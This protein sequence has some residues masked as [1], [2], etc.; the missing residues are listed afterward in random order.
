M[1]RIIALT[2]NWQVSESAMTAP[3]S[4]EALSQLASTTPG[5][6]LPAQM[7]AQVHDVLLAAGRIED[8]AGFGAAAACVWVGERNWV[9]RTRFAAPSARSQRLRFAGVDTIA[10]VYLN[11]K[12]IASHD[13]MFLP[14][15]IDVTGH[16]RDTDNT[17]IVFF[18]SPWQWLK[19]HPLPAHLAGLV[20]H[21]RLLRKPQEDFNAFNGAHPYYTTI[22]IFGDVQLILADGPTLGSV[23]LH[24]GIGEDQKGH[25]SVSGPLHDCRAGEEARVCVRVVAPDGNVV[26]ESEAR[27]GQ[28]DGSMMFHSDLCVAHPA[29]WFPRGY[30]EQPLYTVDVRLCVNGQVCDEV[31]TRA[32]FRRIEVSENFDVT[33]NGVQVRLWGVNLTPVDGHSKR[34]HRART[35]ATLELAE[36]ANCVS[37]RFWGPG[38]PWHDDVYDECDRRGFLVWAE[39][40]HTW[41][42]YPDMPEYLAACRREAAYEVQRLHHH[43]S[44]FLWC[45]SNEVYMGWE[46]AHGNTDVPGKELYEQLYPQVVRELDP[47]Q[48][49]YLV[50]SPYGGRFPNDPQTGNSHSYTHQHFVPGAEH[51]LLFTENTRISPPLVKSLKRFIPPDQFWPEGFISR[52]ALRQR[53]ATEARPQAAREQRHCDASEIPPAWN[54]LTLGADFI[55]GRLGPIGDFYDTGDT[56]DGLVYRLGAAHV[57]WLRDCVERYRRGYPAHDTSRTVRTRGHYL[58]KFNSTWPMIYSDLVDYLMEPN[59]SYYALRRAYAP[60]LISMEI[61]DHINLWVV[62]DAGQSVTGRLEARLYN[63]DGT[64]VLY[65]QCHDVS[66]APGRS[67]MIGNLD[68]AGMFSRAC[69]FFAEL[70]DANGRQIARTNDLAGIERTIAFPD[71]RIQLE[72]HA[73]G[74]GVIVTTDVFAR[75]VEL[76]GKA[77]GGDAFGWLF[78]DNFFDLL[79]HER[80]A[81]RLVGRQRTGEISA[82]SIHAST[83]AHIAL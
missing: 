70:T 44:I 60:V 5:D 34:Y 61:A 55:F 35:H 40:F 10:D 36:A 30:G 13:D 79:P 52:S 26:A 41:G 12:H 56:P 66:V 6:W 69:V 50:S 83:T 82:G 63:P 58:W 20:N 72:P 14:L 38:G 48:R 39:F 81:V 2:D 16:L 37:L 80:K 4:T 23:R 42:G 45:G 77:P 28:H 78:E 19:T 25:I 22:G 27:A 74:N 73:D 8:P 43:P 62:N 3:L 53:R 7:P 24:A 65:Q 54:Q 57:R 1:K 31:S 67:E 32:G 47:E 21:E 29:L 18:T 17:L 15:E 75:C 59:M 33:V 9:Y 49:R 11:G 71:A 76:Q 64:Q 68:G 51:P 46:R